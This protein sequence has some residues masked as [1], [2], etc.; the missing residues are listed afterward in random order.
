VVQQPPYSPEMA[1]CDLCL[2]LDVKMAIKTKRSDDTDTFKQNTKK[3]L[4]SVLKDP[5][6][7][8]SNSGTIAD[9]SA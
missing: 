6:K 2:F 1:P 9:I 5:F 3:H 8:V 4:R 7:N